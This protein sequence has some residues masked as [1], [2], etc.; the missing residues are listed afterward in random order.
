[1]QFPIGKDCVIPGAY[2]VQNV[3]HYIAFRFAYLQ[4]K[5]LHMFV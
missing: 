2:R 1:M 4:Y 5:I 3:F